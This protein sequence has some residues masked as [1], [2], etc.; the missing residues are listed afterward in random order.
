MST[1]EASGGIG[2]GPGS[3]VGGEGVESDESRV[4]SVGEASRRVGVGLGSGVGTG[5]GIAGSGMSET[6]V[7]GI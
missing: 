3:G 5:E 2:V 4:A 1:G 7:S 6:T